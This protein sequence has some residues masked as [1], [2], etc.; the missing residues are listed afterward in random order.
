MIAE[1]IRA[2]EE[3]T[4]AASSA[5]AAHVV[6][7]CG[8]YGYPLGNASAARITTVGKALK[9]SGMNF[10]LLHCG[11]SPDSVNTKRS[12]VYQGI[13][14]EYTAS[15][16]RPKNLP[17]RLLVYTRA[18][19]GLTLRLAR[20][21]PLRHR[22]LVYLY[23]GDGILNFYTGLLCRLLG[24]RLVQELCEWAPGDSNCSAFT[25]WLYRKPIFKLATG[26]LVISKAIED[27]VK[28]RSAE[29]NPGLLIL[30][31][32]SIVDAKRFATSSADD[33]VQTANH[34]VYCGTW[35]KDV[36]FIVRAFAMVRSQGY[37]C[38]LR[39][40]GGWTESR[41]SA[42]LKYA[43]ENNLSADDIVMTGCVDERG[44]EA[45]YRTAAA[46]LT[47][48]W[49]DDRSKT[50]LPNKLGEYL[51][52]GRPVVAGKVG[53]LT[54]FLI[55]DVNACLA[56]PG[57][58]RDFADRMVSVLR[59]PTRAHQIGA[60]GQQASLTHLDYR[61]HSSRLSKFFV[62]CLEHSR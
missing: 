56:E 60:A 11:P 31:L 62:E 45:C 21:R 52:S 8:G 2:D 47:P 17:A 51:A 40:V 12:G 25:R 50:R 23:V 27:R 30:R 24:F 36:F 22:T 20:L 57:D 41:K 59:D 34:F 39:I 33:G 55:D 61:A 26:A 16:K 10:S 48:L 35:L 6:C 29:V 4:V 13:P 15:V 32:P 54:E 38:K 9:R 58:E 5:Q 14:F 43:V 28:E 46:L 7:I 44:L 18:L 1:Q 53:D 3:G 37:D 49:D 19:I 42:I